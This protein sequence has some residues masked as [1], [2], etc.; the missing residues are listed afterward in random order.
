VIFP[1]LSQKGYIVNEELIFILMWSPPKEGGS[2]KM[3]DIPCKWIF[4]PKMMDIPWKW[5]FTLLKWWIYHVSGF[6]LS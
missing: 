2:P 3:V 6:S 1:D 5:I 4:T